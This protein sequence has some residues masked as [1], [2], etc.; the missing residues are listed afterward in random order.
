[1]VGGAGLSKGDVFLLCEI[2]GRSSMRFPI[3]KN[4]GRY[5]DIELP[6]VAIPSLGDT[7]HISLRMEAVQKA[8]FGEKLEF[9]LV[10]K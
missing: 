6:K 2:E 10:P 7:T 8:T 1:M 9:T 4:V 3:P 5:E